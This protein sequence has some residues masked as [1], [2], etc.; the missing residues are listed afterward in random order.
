MIPMKLNEE[1]MPESLSEQYEKLR[2]QKLMDSNKLQY[3]MEMCRIIKRQTANIILP[4]LTNDEMSQLKEHLAEYKKIPDEA[5]PY[6][7]LNLYNSFTLIN[8]F[9]DSNEMKKKLQPILIYLK[10][11]EYIINLIIES[12]GKKET[13][14]LDK[15]MIM[16]HLEI[17]MFCMQY[18]FM[19]TDIDTTTQNFA[20]ITPPNL[21]DEEEFI[22]KVEDLLEQ[23]IPYEETN[24][25][26]QT[27]L[28]QYEQDQE[29]PDEEDEQP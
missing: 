26:E 1:K 5:L 2:N 12:Q 10:N 8:K 29:D 18:A 20:P 27:N 17:N 15:A 22:P 14:I 13:P 16:L 3:N 11:Y 19:L 21:D 25:E 23:D 4:K 6:K 7:F 9:E 24:Y 28:D